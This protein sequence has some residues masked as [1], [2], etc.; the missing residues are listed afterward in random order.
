MIP[1]S[2]PLLRGMLLGPSLRILHEQEIFTWL[3]LDLWGT[4]PVNTRQRSKPCLCS[5]L[6]VLA[7]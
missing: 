2:H 1:H 5:D 4:Q 6:L 7:A 3:R